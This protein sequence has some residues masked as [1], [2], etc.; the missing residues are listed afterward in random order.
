VIFGQKNGKKINEG[1][2]FCGT[3]EAGAEKVRCGKGKIPSAAKAALRT[4]Y[5]RRG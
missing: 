4:E 1:I 3:A 2:A 5:L